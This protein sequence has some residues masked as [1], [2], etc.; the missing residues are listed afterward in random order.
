[1]LVF[2]LTLILQVTGFTR[3]EDPEKTNL[4]TIYLSQLIYFDFA[5]TL[6]IFIYKKKINILMFYP[7][8]FKILI[9]RL[10]GACHLCLSFCVKKRKTTTS[11]WGTTF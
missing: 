10:K 8:I 2:F 5:F 11:F 4:T 7:S 6:I 9:M 1:M 3:I